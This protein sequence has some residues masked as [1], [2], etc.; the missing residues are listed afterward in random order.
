MLACGHKVSHLPS[1]EV[2]FVSDS[3]EAGTF[4]KVESVA[5]GKETLKITSSILP[6]ASSCEYLIYTKDLGSSSVSDI[7]LYKLRFLFP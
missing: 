4:Q 3:N 2:V 6:Y 1:N 7:T 5:K